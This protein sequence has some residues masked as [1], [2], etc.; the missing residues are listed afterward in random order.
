MTSRSRK[1]G[2]TPTSV[3]A[4]QVLLFIL[5]AIWILFG[6]ASLISLVNSSTNPTVTLW[7]V[8]ILMFGNAGALLVIGWG[9]GKQKRLFFYLG[10]IVLAANIFL[11]VTDEFGAFDLITLIIDLALLALLIV[12]RSRYLTTNKE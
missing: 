10:I 7:V 8:A 5:G 1:I 12:T 4:A 11:T 2:E 6:V 9:I 3:K